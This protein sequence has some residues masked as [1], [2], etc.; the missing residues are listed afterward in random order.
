[1][2]IEPF[3]IKTTTLTDDQINTLI[4]WGKSEFGVERYMANIKLC[5]YVG[6]FDQG[7]IQFGNWLGQEEPLLTFEQFEEKYINNNRPELKL[8]HAVKTAL[9]VYLV[10]HDGQKMILLS[11]TS[12]VEVRFEGEYRITEIYEMIDRPEDKSCA[13][14]AINGKLDNYTLIWKEETEEVKALKSKRDK[15]KKELEKIESKL[16]GF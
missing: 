10:A 6:V 7:G 4:Q 13:R 1:M 5:D 12:W 9:G 11:A 8:G 2:K 14:Q 3:A 15:L 16:V